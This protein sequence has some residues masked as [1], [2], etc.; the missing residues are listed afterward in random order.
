LSWVE[1]FAQQDSVT[2]DV[3][4]AQALFVAA[5]AGFHHGHGEQ[6]DI[7]GHVEDH[8]FREPGDPEQVGEPPE[9]SPH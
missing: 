6:H 5:A 8:V 9:S 1:L 7:V 4:V 3:E 2:G